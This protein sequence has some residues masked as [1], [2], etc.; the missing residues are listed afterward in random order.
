M[1]FLTVFLASMLG[2]L[3]SLWIIG[4]IAHRRQVKQAEVIRA[5]FEQTMK[6]VEEKER[7]MREYARMES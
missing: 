1:T 3:A 6:E 7:R 4:A 2:Q 5:T